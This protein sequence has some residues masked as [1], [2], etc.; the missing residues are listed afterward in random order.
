MCSLL[1]K[2]RR[3]RMIKEGGLPDNIDPANPAIDDP[4]ER[5]RIMRTFE[6]RLGEPVGYVLPV[7]RWTARPAPAG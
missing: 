3:E 2:T 4:Q 5:A 7:Q 1:S 6:R